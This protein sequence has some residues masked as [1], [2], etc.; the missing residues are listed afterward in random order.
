[1]KALAAT[2]LR[3]IDFPRALTLRLTRGAACVGNFRAAFAASLGVAPERVQ[4][5]GS[6]RAA[7][8]ALVSGL[9]LPPDAEVLLP[10]YTCAVVPNVFLHLGLPVRYVDIAPGGYNPTAEAVAAAISPRTAL[11]LLPHN[12]GLAMEGLA[13]LR[14]RF[15][16]VVF[17]EDAAH[18]WGTRLAD[19]SMVGTQGQAA[20]FSFEYSKPLSCG[21]G[22]ALVLNDDAL[23]AR[24]PVP[25]LH[26][27][28]ASA[29]FRQ[30]LTL[31]W[32]R[33]VQTLPGPALALLQAL[34]RAPSRLLGLVAATPAAELTGVAQ[35][36]YRLGLAPWSAALGVG[37]ARRAAGLWALRQAQCRVYDD[38]LAGTAW[39][40]PPRAPGDVLV[41]YPVRLP[42]G[43]DRE[44][45]RAALARAGLLMGEWFDDVVHP[46]GSYRHGYTAGDCPVGEA[47]AACVI[48]LPLGLHARLSGAQRRALRAI[49]LAHGGAAA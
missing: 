12:F 42:A 24:L 27:A 11:V 38:V 9:A 46:R 1:M 22:G 43:V 6:G 32:H 16:A 26:M 7:L 37:Q 44:A 36:D 31:A 5:F 2:A 19:G 47:T 20:F 10:G 13:A 45:V 33:L 15:P 35:P 23:R 21:L 29:L 49:A 41:R 40:R 30:T 48:N 14:A 39:Q 25:A 4:L 18:A 34:L 8:H 17:V 28:P 3:W